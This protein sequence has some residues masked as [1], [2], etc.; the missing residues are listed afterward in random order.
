MLE[1]N[2]RV[3]RLCTI[4]KI[5]IETNY[6]SR[7]SGKELPEYCFQTDKHIT[8]APYGKKVRVEKEWLKLIALYNLTMPNGSVDKNKIFDVEFIKYKKIG[9]HTNIDYVV[10]FKEP[11]YVDKNKE[12]RLIAR[13]PN[14]AI[15][16]DGRVMELS[17]KNIMTYD[18]K[19][20]DK[21]IYPSIRLYDTKVHKLNYVL[22]HRLVAVTWCVNKDNNFKDRPL[23]NHKD[24]NKHNYNADNLEWVS[25]SGNTFHALSPNT[26]NTDLVYNNG[27]SVLNIETNEVT[28]HNSM[29]KV[30]E[31]IGR[32]RINLRFDKLNNGKVYSGVN[33]HFLIKMYGNDDFVRSNFS[34]W[35]NY[36][37]VVTYKDG[38][39]EKYNTIPDLNYA[40]LKVKGVM[41]YELLKETI[42]KRRSDVVDVV[43]F[44]NKNTVNKVE[45]MDI[46]TNKI[47]ETSTMR[48]MDRLLGISNSVTQSAYRSNN[49]NKV[50]INKY[51]FKFNG[52][53][54]W[55]KS[56]FI[57]PS[58]N[59]FVYYIENKKI[60]S[61]RKLS[62]YVGIDRAVLA[63]LF[64]NKKEIT[65][66]NVK[67]IKSPL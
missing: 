26:L 24:L 49:P 41:E 8:I 25:G 9:Y 66:K 51:V 37:Y 31:F 18:T 4:F 23:V 42:L 39:E 50:Y 65:I 57:L 21:E 17:S 47:Y 67:I 3:I 60:N 27:F 43:R 7:V 48:E 15:S 36:Y 6:V 22:L 5:N 46:T 38:S 53:G 34:K 64:Q 13:Y 45:A 54:E 12:F 32:A 30:S 63:K 35:I 40:L 1:V 19:K 10:L 58:N 62:N 52:V 20:I 28:H 61:L 29:I 16:K 55:D 44:T 59:P 2:E 56:K 11:I 14:Y 33:G